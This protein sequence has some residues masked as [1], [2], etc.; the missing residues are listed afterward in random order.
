M[1]SGATNDQG[2]IQVDLHDESAILYRAMWG[3][4]PQAF[5]HDL[6]RHILHNLCACDAV[7]IGSHRVLDNDPAAVET[8]GPVPVHVA[9]QVQTILGTTQ[10]AAVDR[11][12]TNSVH[13]LAD[14]LRWDDWETRPSSQPDEH[15]PSH[16][17][18][19]DT[20]LWAHPATPFAR[21]SI[22]V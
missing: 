4:K 10:P 2:A 6:E 15:G 11:F 19:D 1:S 7:L 9:K 21:M 13:F 14:L 18:V 3:G 16:G 22:N 5:L 8:I 20:P 17:P 12:F